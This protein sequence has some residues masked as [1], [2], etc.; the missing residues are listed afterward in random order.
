MRPPW[1]SFCGRICCPRPGPPRRRPAIFGPCCVT[2]SAWSRSGGW[3]ARSPGWPSPTQGPGAHGPARGRLPD[4][5]L[6]AEIG[7]ISRFP[8]ARELCASAA[9]TPGAQ[10]RPQGPPRP[11]HQHGPPWGA[12]DPAGGG[13]TAK[14]HPMF[15]STY[16]ELARRRG[17]NIATVAIA[18]RLLARS[19]HIL[20][21][22]EG[23]A[24]HTGEGPYR[25]RSRSC[26][27]M[28]YGRPA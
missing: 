2:G 19:F 11:H 18:R 12:G 10:L 20:H 15:A 4:M 28:Q 25:A 24:E 6:V 17:N 21:P 3:N 7:D 13:Q 23:P 1:P 9:L 26:M 8:T 5:T 22:A 27:S 16:A 14:R